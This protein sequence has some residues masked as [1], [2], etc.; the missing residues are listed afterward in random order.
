MSDTPDIELD[1]GP[2]SAAAAPAPRRAQGI[3]CWGLAVAVP[4]DWARSV[5]EQFELEPV[6]GAPGWLTGAVN[7]DGHIV[8]VVDLSAL[9]RSDVPARPA[10]GHRLLHGGDG[11]ARFALSFS[12]LPM[13][14]R[15]VDAPAHPPAPLQAFACGAA[16][17]D[18]QSSPVPLLDMAALGRHL[19]ASLAAG[20]SPV[21]NPHLS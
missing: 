8:P 12:G 5:V 10:R 13:L 18:E 2:V 14:L 3:D 6:P 19:V 16:R 17:S 11:A 21:A 7:L 1:L 20:A 15:E 4:Y 9:L